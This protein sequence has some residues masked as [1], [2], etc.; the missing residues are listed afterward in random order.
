M[1]PLSPSDGTGAWRKAAQGSHHVR[2]WSQ[3]SNL[4]QVRAK[5]QHTPHRRV[6]WAILVFFSFFFFFFLFSPRHSQGR[7]NVSNFEGVSYERTAYDRFITFDLSIASTK[8][9]YIKLNTKIQNI[10]CCLNGN[11]TTFL[12]TLTES[13][14][15]QKEKKRVFSFKVYTKVECYFKKWV[16]V[17][18]FMY[19]VLVDVMDRSL[20]SN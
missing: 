6:L 16:W 20:V 8:T 12:Y 19:L 15:K 18:S 3:T 7:R 4:D 14:R 17:F 10:F 11:L 1:L 5:I 13:T 9:K 2:Q